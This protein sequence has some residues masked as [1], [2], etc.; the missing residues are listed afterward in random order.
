VPHAHRAVAASAVRG[1]APLTDCSIIVPTLRRAWILERLHRSFAET[2]HGGVCE[3]L[4]VCSRDDPNS[5]QAARELERA[6]PHVRVITVDWAGGTRGDSARKLN[7]GARA[8]RGEWLLACDDDVAFHPGWLTE[9]QRIHAATGAQVIGTNDL[10]NPHV[11][12]G[13][14]STKPCFHRQ[15]LPEGT[16]DQAGLLYHEGYWHNGPDSEACETAKARGTWAFANEAIIEHLHPDWGKA[17]DDATYRLH[18]HRYRKDE[19]LLRRRQG[20]WGGAEEPDWRSRSHFGPTGL[21]I[22]ALR[23]LL[24]ASE[25]STRPVGQALSAFLASLR[26]RSRRR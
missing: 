11:V 15:Y 12:A 8:A 7:A 16:I 25:R 13:H 6:D 26:S 17:S 2:D 21:G 5:L 18:R 19:Q 14:S 23:Q 24:R 9:V 4:L 1:V 3:L 10:G 22:A 20:L